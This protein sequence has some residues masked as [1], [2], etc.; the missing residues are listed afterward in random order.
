MSPFPEPAEKGQR[1]LVS[2]TPID[3]RPKSGLLT[4]GQLV[5]T[6]QEDFPQLTISKVR[7]L[8]DR[9]LLAPPRTQGGYRSY[10][11]ED[12]RRLRTILTL[13]RD[14]FLP[15][16][17]IQQRLERGM[18]T[19]VGRRL[20]PGP[21]S[22]VAETLHRQERTFTWAEAAEATGIDVDLLRQLGEYRLVEGT[23]VGEGRLTETDLE[24]A[25]V[26]DLLARFGVEPRNLRLLRSSVEREVALVE[27]VVAP[28]LRSPHEER[29]SQGE[30]TL[31][32][33]ATLLT[34]LLDHLL[35]KELR[36][37]VE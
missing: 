10:G 22:E 5:R 36:R 30:Q 19:A 9:G 32:D 8:E 2:E 29:R 17:V 4:I 28:D 34:Q 7:Y 23:S 18:A 20:R 14:D 1:R 6:L 15:L 24:I 3:L 21:A 27:Q 12:V 35:Y 37:L 25:R 16:D 31:Q 26:C 11:P 13:Q 33:L